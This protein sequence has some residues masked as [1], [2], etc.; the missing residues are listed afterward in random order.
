MRWFSKKINEIFKKSLTLTTD[1]AR[2]FANDL[3]RA[4]DEAEDHQCLW[5]VTLYSKCRD[6]LHVTVRPFKDYLAD[7]DPELFKDEK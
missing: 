6:V 7:E 3:L 4:A 1:D 2:V 5:P